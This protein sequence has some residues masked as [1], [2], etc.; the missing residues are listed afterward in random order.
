MLAHQR[1]RSTGGLSVR[2]KALLFPPLSSSNLKWGFFSFV[3]QQA[4]QNVGVA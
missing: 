3:L 4:E 1:G 2:S